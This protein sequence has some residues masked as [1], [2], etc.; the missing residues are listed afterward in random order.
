MDRHD[1]CMVF[2]KMNSVL[3]INLVLSSPLF[4]Q[5]FQRRLGQ[6]FVTICG[7]PVTLLVSLNTFTDGEYH[8]APEWE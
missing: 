8:S 5:S 3:I 7:D 2:V 4:F 1:D 6:K